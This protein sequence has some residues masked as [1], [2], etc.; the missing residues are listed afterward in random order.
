[1]SSPSSSFNCFDKKLTRL[2]QPCHKNFARTHKCAVVFENSIPDQFF[3]FTDVLVSQCIQ[4]LIC[5]LPSPRKNR[6]SATEGYKRLLC[7]LAVS[8]M[9][10]LFCTVTMYFLLLM[11]F[12]ITQ[13]EL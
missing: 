3:C 7:V 11:S 9:H 4:G 10:F 5:I 13:P 12:I 6:I 1:M 8:G 2:R